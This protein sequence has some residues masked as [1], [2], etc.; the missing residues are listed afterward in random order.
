MVERSL[1]AADAA[2]IEAQHRKSAMREGVVALVDDLV[3]HGAV[4]LRM[5]M[6]YHRD[7]RI[8]L[9]RW[10]ITAFEA[11]CG[12]GENDFR[13]GDPLANQPPLCRLH[14]ALLADEVLAG[15]KGVDRASSGS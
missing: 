10:V 13:H 4:K 2:K 7:R 14:P 3:V 1:A 15:D 5:R 6:Q 9:L 11:A 8:L 12:A